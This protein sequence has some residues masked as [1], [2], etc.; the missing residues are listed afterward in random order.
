MLDDRLRL[1]AARYGAEFD[2]LFG[3]TS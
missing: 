2:R 1:E 3:A